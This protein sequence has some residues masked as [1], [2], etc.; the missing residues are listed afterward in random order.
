ML[1][2]TYGRDKGTIKLSFSVGKISPM[3]YSLATNQIRIYLIGFNNNKYDR[4]E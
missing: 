2:F 4:I 1:K 3:K